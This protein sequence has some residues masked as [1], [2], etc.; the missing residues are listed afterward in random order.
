MRRL[1]CNRK[2]ARRDSMNITASTYITPVR[3]ATPDNE[4][5]AIRCQR[6]TPRPMIY[7]I[8]LDR[9]RSRVFMC[10]GDGVPTPR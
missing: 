8:D 4:V 1:H 6:L 3:G 7:W 5:D 10:V 9:E 2:E